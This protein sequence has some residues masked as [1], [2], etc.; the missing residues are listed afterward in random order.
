MLTAHNM[1]AWR[2]KF[3]VRP[4]GTS[5]AYRDPQHAEHP[6]ARAEH[7]HGPLAVAGERPAVVPLA[8]HADAALGG[9]VELWG[10]V[11]KGRVCGELAAV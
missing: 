4:T 10:G 2:A 1:K 5:V 11:V 3:F 7:S 9:A 8:A 6:V